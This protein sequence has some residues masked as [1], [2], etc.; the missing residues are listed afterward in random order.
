MVWS[1]GIQAAVQTYQGAKER[2]L[3]LLNAKTGPV[4]SG[5]VYVDYIQH[6]NHD[7]DYS[8]LC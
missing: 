5:N 3:K 1:N 8:R 6:Y 2:H 4:A 7:P